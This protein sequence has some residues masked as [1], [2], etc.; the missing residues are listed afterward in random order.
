[1]QSSTLP[2]FENLAQYELNGVFIDLHNDYECKEITL[3]NGDLRLEFKGN[4]NGKWVRLSFRQVDFGAFSIFLSEGKEGLIL[5]NL[6]RGRI[7]ENGQ[8]IETSDKGKG[9]FY[10]EFYAGQKAEF[11]AQG[12]EADLNAGN[13]SL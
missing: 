1:M 2:L 3:I 4:Q 5:D 9:Y 11:W 10:L 7:I 8:L 6:Y 12:L 13:S